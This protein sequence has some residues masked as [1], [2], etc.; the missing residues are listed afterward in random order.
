MNQFLRNEPNLL[1]SEILL[2]IL[3][4]ETLSFMFP[5]LR[6]VNKTIRDTIDCNV[7]LERR[8]QHEISITEGWL[9]KLIPYPKLLTI[10]LSQMTKI[11]PVH[12]N[13]LIESGQHK[14]PLVWKIMEKYQTND[15]GGIALIPFVKNYSHLNPNKKLYKYLLS[16]KAIC[17]RSILFRFLFLETIV[18]G[19]KWDLISKRFF[20]DNDLDLLKSNLKSP[21]FVNLVFSKIETQSQFIS[22]YNFYCDF[23]KNFSIHFVGATTF[24]KLLSRGKFEIVDMV[25]RQYG[26]K[27]IVIHS[28]EFISSVIKGCEF[29]LNN[30]RKFIKKYINKWRLNENQELLKLIAIDCE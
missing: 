28:T 23:V 15:F 11:V 16:T 2:L 25:F 20:K 17:L 30:G 24:N 12:L 21:E 29:D 8:F 7:H 6:L 18:L 9:K 5:I 1:E 26:I 14:H 27:L 22:I 13:I 3:D 19:E 10:I 4:E